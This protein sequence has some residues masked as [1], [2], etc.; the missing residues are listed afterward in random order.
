MNIPEFVIARPKPVCVAE[1]NAIAW[2][3]HHD[4]LS[5]WYQS[6]PVHVHTSTQTELC[7]ILAGLFAVTYCHWGLFRMTCSELVGGRVVILLN[8]VW[9]SMPLSIGFSP[10][11]YSGLRCSRYTRS[12]QWRSG[13]YGFS[14]L[15]KPVNYKEMCIYLNVLLHLMSWWLKCRV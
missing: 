7:K 11:V 2:K 4:N 14:R 15:P 1:S 12:N 3:V 6:D 8:T 13:E 10:P 9:I 5:Q